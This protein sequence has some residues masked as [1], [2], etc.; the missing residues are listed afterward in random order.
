MYIHNTYI[1]KWD[2]CAGNAILNALGGKMTTLT[3]ENITYG[4]ELSNLNSGGLVATFKHHKS[5]I[6]VL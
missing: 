2:I 6:N 5:Y 3:G 4:S 1:K